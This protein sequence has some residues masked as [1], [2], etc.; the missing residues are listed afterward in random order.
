LILEMVS[1]AGQKLFNL[2]QSHFSSLAFIFPEMRVLFR[3]VFLFLCLQE[4]SLCFPLAVSSFWSYI[5]N[6]DPF[7]MDFVQGEG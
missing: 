6:S 3:K 1:F 2:M 7:G 4:F 5:K